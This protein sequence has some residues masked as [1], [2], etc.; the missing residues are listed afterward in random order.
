MTR[1]AF[2]LLF[3]WVTVAIGQVQSPQEAAAQ[4]AARIS[5]Q[6]PRHPTVSLEL[7]S[8]SS[9]TPANLSGFRKILDDEL[10]KSGL[11]ITATQPETRLRVTVSE[12]TRGLLLV[13]ELLTG[14][15][16]TVILQPWTPPPVSET[17]PRLRIIRKPIWDQSEP[18]LDILVLNS[19]SQ[20]LLLSPTTL[21][22]YRMVSGQWAP[23]DVAALSLAR[24]AARDPRGRI[25]TTA[26]GLRIYVPGTTCSATLQPS[27]RLVCAPA[28][29][30]W[31]V[32]PRDTSLVARWVTDRNILESPSF[33]KGF[34]DG[35]SGWFSAVDHRLSDRAVNSL[36]GTESWGSDFANVESSCVPDPTVIA[37]GSGDHPDHD[38]AQVYEIAAANATPVSEPM[39]L[40]G[41]I[42]ALWPA[43]IAGQAT[44]VV[45]N[46]KTG[47]YEASRLGVAC[48]DD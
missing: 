8:Q 26:D 9:G 43:E 45:R 38:Q 16:R 10:R 37:S 48:T 24:P 29:D 14:E 30:P 35:A 34:Y 5:S 25:Q 33:Q 11:P 12:N 13:A 23:T 15:N 31:P 22:S 41:P 21:S 46:S 3:G 18:I 27:L 28:N 47:N 20:L 7:Q 40:P 4:L 17:K 39:T 6:L 19:D 1:V 42:T 32:N 36:A 44:L 2:A